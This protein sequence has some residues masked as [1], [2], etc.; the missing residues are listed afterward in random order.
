MASSATDLLAGR[1]GRL[2]RIRV[3]LAHA[4][5]R[6]AIGDPVRRFVEE[7]VEPGLVPRG[8]GITA[9]LAA[10]DAHVSG[11]RFARVAEVLGL[12]ADRAGSSCSPR[13]RRRCGAASASRC[14]CSAPRSRPACTRR[15]TWSSS[16]PP[17]CEDWRAAVRALDRAGRRRRADPPARRARLAAAVGRD[18]ADPDAPRVARRS[19]RAVRAARRRAAA[20]PARRARG[21]GARGARGRAAHRADPRA[22][23][24]SRTG[25]AA[26]PWSRATPASPSST[27]GCA[28]A[29]CS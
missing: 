14:S 4:R 5:G 7:N 12:D 18:R 2:E 28:T 15:R 8:E 27:P 1:R 23:P 9:A 10:I 25:S 26:A 6:T 16:S 20:A 29:C 11:G 22:P 17:R 21:A 13:S 19:R 3:L 24:R